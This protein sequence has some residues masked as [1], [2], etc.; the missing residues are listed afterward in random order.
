MQHSVDPTEPSSPALDSPVL[1][2][3]LPEGAPELRQL[4]L[5]ERRHRLRIEGHYD[6]F[7]RLDDLKACFT[8]LAC[9]EIRGALCVVAGFMDMASEDL[10]DS[11][12][13]STREI[14]AAAGQQVDRLTSL[15][16]QLGDFSQMR[17]LHTGEAARGT[18]DEILSGLAPA[19]ETQF[20]PQ[21]F[22]LQVELDP[23]GAGC[24]LYADLTGLALRALVGN[25]QR[26]ASGP[27]R[28]GIRSR[29]RDST[30]EVEIATPGGELAKELRDEVLEG[31]APGAGL[32]EPQSGGLALG[33]WIAWRAA[34]ALG[35]DLVM[36]SE[37]G[38]GVRF[39]LRLPVE[40]D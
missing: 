12:Q 15:L 35:G 34:A 14:L 33:L 36:H 30:L 13:E 22:D 5:E 39:T 9:H 24:L 40:A 16:Q 28:L 6:E 31:F 23:A 10:L 26:L 4:L 1:E 29:R 20:G 27:V 11:L 37:R 18:L 21:G 3:P 17:P 25:F 8:A 2:D 19:L 38:V 7:C 32:P